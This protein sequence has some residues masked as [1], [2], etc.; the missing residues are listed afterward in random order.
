MQHPKYEQELRL[1]MNHINKLLVLFIVILTACS[2]NQNLPP[3]YIAVTHTAAQVEQVL[4]TP[5][6]SPPTMEPTEEVS[7]YPPARG[8]THLLL[9]P[10]SGKMIMFSGESNQRISYSDTWEYDPASNIWT[11]RFPDTHPNGVG[12]TAS[13]YDSESDKFIFYF[14]TVLDRSA[15]KGLIAISETWA[16]DFETNTWENMNPVTHPEGI[17]GA[18][19]AY[20]S[21]SDRVI[22]F[23]GADFTADT[24]TTFTET[25]SY[26]YN[27]NTWEKMN[28]SQTPIGRSYYGSAYAAS[29]DRVFV[30]GGRVKEEDEVRQNQ[31][32]AYDYNT[33]AW[34]EI[35]Y[36]GEPNPDHHAMMVYNSTTDQLLYLVNRNLMAFDLNTQSWE[37]LASSP[38]DA[39]LH[40]HSMVVTPTGSL[41]VFGG[42]PQGLTYNNKMFKYSMDSQEWEQLGP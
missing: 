27:A 4:S 28:P 5:T 1:F 36:T 15:P 16:Y 33:D 31:L 29:Q 32:W 26:D 14:S 10:P 24:T 25:W 18:R 38:T 19:M 34:T 40:F 9:H 3:T 12:G 35:N 11:E 21:E 6:T 22:F 23:G 17:M 30:F 37:K 2:P 39:P 42:G 13:A 8:F 7:E 20:D 41:I